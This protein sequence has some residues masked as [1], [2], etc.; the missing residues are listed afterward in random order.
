MTQEERLASLTEAFIRESDGY[1]HLEVPRNPEE[2]R[3]LLRSLMNIRLPRPLP[4]DIQQM[5]DEYLKEQARE[6][7]IVTLR[8]IPVIREQLHSSRPFADT[9][10]LWQGDITRLKADAIVN[11][12]NEE[13]LGCFIP[14]HACIDNQIQTFA[15]VQMRMECARQMKALRKMHGPHYTQPT[16]VPMITPGYNLPAK[17]VIHIVGP[18]VHHHLTPELEKE[19]VDCYRNVLDLCLEKG[20]KSVA[21]CCISTGVFRFP[22]KRAVEIAVSTVTDWLRQHPGAM[23]CVIFNVFKDEDREIYETLLS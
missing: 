3:R 2:Q 6:K 20:L 22:A 1:R 18:V 17:Y 12:A 4:E 5:Q 13:M 9:I 19:L 10:S 15:G 7:G 16:A 11:A 8:E 23:D 14:L 21:F